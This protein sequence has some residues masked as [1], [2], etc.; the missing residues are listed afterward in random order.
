MLG[1]LKVGVV[2]NKLPVFF[3]SFPSPNCR[4]DLAINCGGKVDNIDRDDDDN[5]DDD[6]GEGGGSNKDDDGV[7]FNATGYGV[8]GGKEE[9]DDDEKEGGGSNN[10]CCNDDDDDKL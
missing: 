3:S 6:D 5:D 8:S 1:P 4:G 2:A 7:R 10:D 9:D